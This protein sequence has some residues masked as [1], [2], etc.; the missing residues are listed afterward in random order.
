MEGDRHAR[1]GNHGHEQLY[2]ARRAVR[3]GQVVAVL[4]RPKATT[5]VEVGKFRFSTQMLRSSAAPEDDRH[6]VPVFSAIW[7]KWFRSSVVPAGDRHAV[8]E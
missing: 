8:E 6:N 4:C 2:P 1:V 5:T 7:P 3:G